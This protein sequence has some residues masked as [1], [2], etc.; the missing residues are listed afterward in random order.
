LR[1]CEP[2]QSPSRAHLQPIQETIQGKIYEP[3]RAPYCK[4]ICKPIYEPYVF[5]LSMHRMDLVG[6]IGLCTSSRCPLETGLWSWP[7]QR[8]TR[9]DTAHAL[10]TYTGSFSEVCK[11]GA[12]ATLQRRIFASGQRLGGGR[13]LE[14]IHCPSG[15][16]STATGRVPLWTLRASS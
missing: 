1:S 13:I 2:I 5:T 16:Q 6:E 4:P 3:T 8:R 14:R 9:H 15:G 12:L 10:A 11:T 7:T